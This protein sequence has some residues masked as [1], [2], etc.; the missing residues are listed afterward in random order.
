VFLKNIARVEVFPFLEYMAMTVHALEERELR[1]AMNSVQEGSEAKR[2]RAR[3]ATA[4]S[5]RIGI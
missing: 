3:R 2:R 1:Q 4:T 5:V